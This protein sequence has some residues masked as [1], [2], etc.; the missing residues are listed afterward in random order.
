[1]LEMCLH[2]ARAVGLFL[3]LGLFVLLFS[4]C[5]HGGGWASTL[6]AVAY[7]SLTWSVF[8]PVLAPIFVSF[9]HVFCAVCLSLP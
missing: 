3:I 6:R 4:C 9:F 7:P 2:L 8:P 5:D 1:M